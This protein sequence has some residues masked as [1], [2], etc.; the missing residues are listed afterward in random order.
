[1]SNNNNESTMKYKIDIGELKSGLQQA[2]REIRKANSEFKAAQSGMDNWKT[3]TEGLSSKLKQ[4]DTVCSNQKKILSNLEEQY[5]LTAEEMGKDSKAA[6]DLEIRI[7]NQKGE[8]AKTERQI[9]TYNDKLS[10]LSIAQKQSESAL[11]KLNNKINEQE[12]E[13]SSLKREYQNYILSNE[14]GSS[15]AKE[16]ENKISSLSS[17]NTDRGRVKSASARC[18]GT[19]RAVT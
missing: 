8:I 18:K 11:G 3:S 5:T 17:E 1:M 19:C 4:L 15:A 9:R 13:L 14:Q 16:L 7:N 2:R 6:Q 10:E 12:Q